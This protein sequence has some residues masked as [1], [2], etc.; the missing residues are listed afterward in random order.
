V[1]AIAGCS[2]AP[3]PGNEPLYDPHALP[4]GPVGES[5]AYGHTIVAQTRRVLPQ[6][7]KADLSCEACHINGG[8]QARGGTFVGVY[9]RFPQWNKRAHRVIT[10]QD[11]IAECFLY[12][13]NGKAPPYESSEMVAVV[14]YIAW[15]SRGTKV[16]AP[17]PAAEG[18]IEPLPTSSPDVAAGA[19][20]Y[21]QKC[22]MCHR[23]NGAGVSGTF[24]PLWGSTSFNSGAGMAHIDRMTG[25]VHYNM[26]QNAPGTLSLEQAYDVSAFVL[27]HTRPRFNGK[28]TVT[29][30][31]PRP[32]KYF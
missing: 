4:T 1:I 14:A 29:A 18:F 16:G 9:S 19:T 8:T 10:L 5:I 22:V 6:Y 15:L 27:Q 12:S 11:R 24:P 21:Q 26:P 3:A 25:F 28:A 32:A 30:S 17:Q 23:A 13:M 2:S 7:V 31:E 20:I